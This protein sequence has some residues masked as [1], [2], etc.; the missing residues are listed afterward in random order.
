MSLRTLAFV[1]G[2][3]L[4]AAATA[5]MFVSAPLAAAADH[6]T[7][8]ITVRGDSSVTVMPENSSPVIVVLD[9]NTKMVAAT[10]AITTRINNLD[11]FNVVDKL[12]VYFKYGRSQVAPE[13][14]AQLQEFAAKAKGIDGYRIQVQGYA[15]A[16]GPRAVNEVLSMRR[17]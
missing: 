7:G 16:V 11:E 17:A 12:I 1:R 8:V 10:G 4:A 5:A 14:A 15:S 2:I 13:F 9:E 3:T 6:V